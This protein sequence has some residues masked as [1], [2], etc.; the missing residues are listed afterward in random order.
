M[1]SVREHIAAQRHDLADT[2]R[3]LAGDQW[4]LPTLCGGMPVRDLVAHVCS[5]SMVVHWPFE[6]LFCT[7]DN[8]AVAEGVAHG[9]AD[10]RGEETA[11]FLTALVQAPLPDPSRN[12]SRIGLLGLLAH[13]LLHSLDIT[14]A[15]RLSLT[16]PP[17]R[18][19][20]VLLGVLTPRN[21]HTLGIDLGRVQLLA[22]DLAWSA[23]IGQPA[24]GCASDLLLAVHGRAIPTG[25]LGGAGARMLTG[26]CR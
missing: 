9:V 13:D 8:V 25:R 4:N 6:L 1:T 26:E 21:L 10:A 20:L 24:V 16:I 2:L 12:P 3:L 17:D 22:P 19:R 23:G 11:P 18:M 14:S 5:A 7:G 15:L